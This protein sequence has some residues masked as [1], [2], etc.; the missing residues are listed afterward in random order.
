MKILKYTLGILVG[1]I[2][3][4]G[5]IFYSKVHI[6]EPKIDKEKITYATLEKIGEDSYRYG[7]NKLQKNDK[8][9]WEMYLE[10]KPYE[11]GVAFG[12]LGQ[13]LMNKKEAA[14]VGEIKNRV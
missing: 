4:L 3:L 2:L 5:L 6:V 13:D 14:F 11:R 8:G 12:V 9:L 7:N 1:L 10:G